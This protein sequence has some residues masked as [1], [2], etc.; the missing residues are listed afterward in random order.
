MKILFRVWSVIKVLLR[1]ILFLTI[2]FLSGLIGSLIYALIIYLIFDTSSLIRIK[3]HAID[4]TA[5][6]MLICYLMYTKLEKYK[7]FDFWGWMFVSKDKEN[8]D[9]WKD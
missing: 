5:I 3:G 1:I 8:I 9:V 6:A 2:L 7:I 4:I